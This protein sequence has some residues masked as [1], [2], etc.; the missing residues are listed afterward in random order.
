[1]AYATQADWDAAH[2]VYMAQAVKDRVTYRQVRADAVSYGR[3]T[4]A[5]FDNEVRG[6]IDEDIAANDSR[7]WVRAA[8]RVQNW[9]AG[10]ARQERLAALDDEPEH[11]CEPVGWEERAWAKEMWRRACDAQLDRC[12]W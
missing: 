4:N 2:K 10:I 3:L 6:I 11:D 7:E 9:E 5:Q 1:M 8:H 12:F